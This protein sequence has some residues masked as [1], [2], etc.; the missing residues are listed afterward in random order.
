MILYYENLYLH[1]HILNVYTFIY[2]Y[3]YICTYKFT[4]NICVFYVS[5]IFKIDSAFSL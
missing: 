2:T 4:L 5:V 3:L 1:S